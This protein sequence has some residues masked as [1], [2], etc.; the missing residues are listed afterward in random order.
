MQQFVRSFVGSWGS[1]EEAKVQLERPGWGTISVFVRDNN[2]GKSFQKSYESFQISEAL[3]DC[4]AWC[5]FE[6]DVFI[7]QHRFKFF[8]R[9]Q[10]SLFWLCSCYVDLDIYTVYSGERDFDFW[11]SLILSRC[12]EVN[13]PYPSAII[14][15][16]RGFYL[17]WY[18]LDG[19][20][21]RALSKWNKIQDS[22]LSKFLD[23]GA[24]KKARDAS[25]VF[26]VLGTINKKSG[27]KVQAVWLCPC[28]K[29][30]VKRYT[31]RELGNA[32]LPYTQEE[33]EIWKKN[34]VLREVQKSLPF[35]RTSKSLVGLK[36][37][38]EWERVLPALQLSFSMRGRHV[39]D[40]LLKLALM[41]GWDKTGIPDGERA[42]FMLWLCNHAALALNGAEEPRVYQEVSLFFKS[43]VPH[44]KMH[45]IHSEMHAVYKRSKAMMRPEGWVEFR[46]KV[47]PSL[48]TPKN[49]S[50]VSWL[51]I[52]DEELV[53]L[54]YIRTKETRAEQTK[55]KRREGGALERGVYL[56]QAEARK[57]VVK[58][59]RLEGKTLRE[60]ADLVGITRDRVKVLL[61]D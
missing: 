55:R 4:S 36:C 44:W 2:T 1:R 29:E 40:D 52:T 31:L 33:Y 32:V 5:F 46:G 60:I 10:L 18:L 20:P 14:D 50:L 12:E 3:E 13:I 19:A 27:Q 58:T 61:R 59:L 39:F 49:E 42:T 30:E 22:L 51:G 43:L 11:V 53:Q 8:N 6:Q 23:F 34:G 38:L 15:S 45:K 16:G 48:Y 41:R 17:K 28:D 26:R 56:Q 21:G 24:D 7:T 35:E 25:R 9:Q 47:Y 37:D 57:K 54:D